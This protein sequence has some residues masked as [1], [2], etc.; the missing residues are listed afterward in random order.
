LRAS[1]S[2]NILFRFLRGGDKFIVSGIL[3]KFAAGSSGINIYGNEENAQKIASHE[4]LGLNS[5]FLAGEPGLSF[6]LMA[7]VNYLGFCVVALSVIPIGK[8]T[9]H[10]WIKD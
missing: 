7:L 8:N 3:F 5:F 10:V 2:I 6:P 4:L 1:V 9:L